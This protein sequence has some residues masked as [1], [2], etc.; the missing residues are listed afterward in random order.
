MV[1]IK[2][3]ERTYELATNRELMWEQ[4]AQCKWLRSGDKNTNFFHAYAS[5]KSVKIE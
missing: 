1:Y 3:N 5:S 4:R 2:T